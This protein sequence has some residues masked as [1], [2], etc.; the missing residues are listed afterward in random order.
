M[1]MLKISAV[2]IVIEIWY[3]LGSGTHF[4]YKRGPHI[5]VAF[6]SHWHRHKL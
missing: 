3:H 4:S 6:Y 2:I 1:D 5:F